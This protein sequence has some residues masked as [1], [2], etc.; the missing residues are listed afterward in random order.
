[1]KPQIC[2]SN[3][4]VSCKYS[5]KPLQSYT[6]SN[7]TPL[8]ASNS[9]SCLQSY[10]EGQAFRGHRQGMKIH[11]LEL[12]SQ[13]TYIYICVIIYVILYI[14]LCLYIYIWEKQGKCLISVLSMVSCYHKID[15]DST[16]SKLQ[17]INY[18]VN[19]GNG[20]QLVRF[21]PS[22]VVNHLAGAVTRGA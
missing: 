15:R 5:L 4:W 9:S 11:H 17:I 14:I 20:I 3:M 22:S 7:Y 1:M 8:N 12:Q 18:I 6:L 19:T 2:P 16:P 21:E 13:E 10:K